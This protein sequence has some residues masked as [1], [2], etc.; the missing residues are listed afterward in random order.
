MCV[1]LV[2][3]LLNS[4]SE[5]SNTQIIVGT[6]KSSH[7]KNLRVNTVKY[8]LITN[9]NT[10]MVFHPSD[11]FDIKERNPEGLDQGWQNTSILPKSTSIY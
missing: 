3:H 4:F 11:D 2:A 10:K 6:N 9:F 7:Y 1:K 8:S 5:V